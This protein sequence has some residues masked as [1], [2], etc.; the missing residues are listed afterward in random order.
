[1]ESS[2]P[3]RFSC[4]FFPALFLPALKVH[5][6]FPSPV[7]VF[8][9]LPIMVPDGALRCNFPAFRAERGRQT[10]FGAFWDT[11]RISW[12][13]ICRSRRKID[14]ESDLRM[15]GVRVTKCKLFCFRF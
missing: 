10:H 15:F 2:F 12:I 9:L 4:L 8:L 14:I 7:S 11:I 13:F 1:M 6:S 3:L 5:M